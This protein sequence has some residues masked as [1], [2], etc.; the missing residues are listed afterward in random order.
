VTVGHDDKEKDGYSVDE[1]EVD[2]KAVDELI[3][4]VRSKVRASNHQR[5]I[6]SLHNVEI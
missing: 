5:T 1:D 4:A 3:S 2:H 6:R